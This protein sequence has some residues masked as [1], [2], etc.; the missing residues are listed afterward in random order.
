[1]GT[2]PGGRAGGSGGREDPEN[3]KFVYVY[4]FAAARGMGTAGWGQAPAAAV[5]TLWQILAHRR[6]I[7]LVDVELGTRDGRALT[8]PRITIME[9]GQVA[10]RLQLGWTLPDPVTIPVAAATGI[11]MA[12][13]AGKRG[14]RG[15]APGAP[16]RRARRRGRAA[17]LS[18]RRSPS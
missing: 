13:V 16:R 1:M 17:A 2:G 6:E 11:V 9:E 12:M 5:P 8:L 14:P 7:V 15:A 18:R 10:L 3:D 4:E